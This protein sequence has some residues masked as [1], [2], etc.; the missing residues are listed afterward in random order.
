ML[1]PSQRKLA[2]WSISD[3]EL[4]SLLANKAPCSK[5]DH[6]R[7]KLGC[8]NIASASSLV[9]PAQCLML[10]DAAICP[11]VIVVMD[12]KEKMKERILLGSQHAS[13]SC[14]NPKN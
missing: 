14:L 1:L 13:P 4:L 9:T 10:T 3:I 6:T 8:S 2:G 12:G 11:V 7:T 5:V